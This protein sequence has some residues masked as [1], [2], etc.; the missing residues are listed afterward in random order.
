VLRRWFQ[1]GD[2]ITRLKVPSTAARVD[3]S[4]LISVGADIKPS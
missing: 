2:L 4:V 3:P 1:D